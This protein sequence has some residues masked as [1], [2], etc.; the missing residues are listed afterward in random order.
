MRNLFALML[1]LVLCG[2]LKT[3]NEIYETD[4]RVAS[5]QIKPEEQH[6]AEK[7]SRVQEAEANIRQLNGRIESIEQ[8]LNSDLAE[9]QKDNE[10]KAATHA[11]L[12]EQLKL[13][14][15]RL[16]KLEAELAELKAPKSNQI[17]AA[18]KIGGEK[19]SAEGPDSWKEA[20]ALFEK[21]EW[22]K[23]IL[24][25]QKYREQNVKGK[26]FPDATYKIGVSFH[27]LGKKEEAKAFYEEVVRDYPR[28]NAARKA[29]FRLK[30]LK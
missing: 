24:A 28:S 7:E 2:C 26:N 3:R 18:V 27:E 23:S 9:K 29:Q 25:Y 8:R 13:N 16:A 17:P 6:A 1:M 12:V 10:L 11:Q 22:T 19:T 14:E 15:E 20:E 4:D 21:K 30:S 5:Q